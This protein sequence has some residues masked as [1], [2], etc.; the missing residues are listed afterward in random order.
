MSLRRVRKRDGRELRFDRSKIAAA[1]RAA[2]AAV[3]ED[4]PTVADEVAG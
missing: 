4:D 2:Q 1:V 3:G